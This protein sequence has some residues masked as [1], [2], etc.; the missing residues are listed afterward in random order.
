[1]PEFTFVR[2][3]AQVLLASWLTPNVFSL[4]LPV[5]RCARASASLTQSARQTLSRLDGILADNAEPL[6]DTIANI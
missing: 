4:F 1:M 2:L 6:E 3:S 5:S